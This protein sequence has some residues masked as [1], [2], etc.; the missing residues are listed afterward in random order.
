MSLIVEVSDTFRCRSR[1]SFQ[2]FL[3]GSRRE[4]HFMNFLLAYRLKVILGLGVRLAAPHHTADWLFGVV[5]GVILERPSLSAERRHDEAIRL[6]NLFVALYHPRRTTNTSE[7]R[8]PHH[9]L[10][11]VLGLAS[12]RMTHGGGED[13]QL[14]AQ[15]HQRSENLSNVLFCIDLQLTEV[16]R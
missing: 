4:F 16:I 10:H 11:R 8:R 6:V 15:H 9:P 13:V 1:S 7:P 12:I 5:F 3:Q 2:I 14:A